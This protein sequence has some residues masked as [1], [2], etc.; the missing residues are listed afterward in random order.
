M[1]HPKRRSLTVQTL[2]RVLHSK[3]AVTG[4]TILFVIVLLAI[5]APVISNALHVSPTKMD[6]THANLG[7]SWQHLCGTDDNGSD[8]F[9]RLLYGARYSLFLGLTGAL[10]STIVGVIIGAFAGYF[11]RWTDNVIMRFMD[12]LQSIP[13]ILIA[14]L[15]AAVLGT[16]FIKTIIALTVGGIVPAVRI[17]RGQILA[18]RTREYVEAAES[19]NCGRLRIMFSEVLPNTLSPLIVHITTAIGG[20]ILVAT[21][22]SY[23][24]FGVR[25]P[26]PEWG[27]MLTAGS[28][29]VLAHPHIVLFPGLAIVITVLAVSIFGDGLRDAL[30]PKMKR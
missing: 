22:L 21:A 8:I 27:A 29:V 7:P 10:F 3:L 12:V 25:P 26:T 30:D 24:G 16:G 18:E 19:I 28:G 6:I 23:I 15:I 9:S 2:V 1:T 5:L 11:G 17:T 20:T 14:I 4:M 13:G